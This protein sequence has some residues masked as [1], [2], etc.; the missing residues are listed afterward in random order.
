MTD[1]AP[2]TEIIIPKRLIRDGYLCVSGPAWETAKG[3]ERFTLCLPVALLDDPSTQVLLREEYAGA[4]YEARERRL[5]DRFLPPD[6]LFLDVGAHWGIYTLHALTAH[7]GVQVIAVEPD[8]DNLIHL[9]RNLSE[10]KLDGRTTVVAAAVAEQAGTR[11]L[12]RNTSMGH[13]IVSDRDRAGPGAMAVRI[14]T[15]DALVAAADPG[16]RRPI[17]IK[18]DIEGRERSALEGAAETLESG[19]V[20]GILWEIS[21]GGLVNPDVDTIVALLAGY[22]FASYVVNDDYRLSLP[23]DGVVPDLARVKSF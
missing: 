2:R 3:A 6:S 8:R 1:A 11:W 15:I 22:N 9:A 23:V 12:R 14:V 20:A 7:A 13:H 19:R 5:V 16:R 18:L 10:N 17:W 21:V 4:G